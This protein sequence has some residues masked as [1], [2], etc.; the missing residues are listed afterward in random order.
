MSSSP[1][2]DYV[3]TVSS[4]TETKQ[5]LTFDAWNGMGKGVTS[6]I[7]M[8]K[9]RSLA[10]KRQHHH[11]WRYQRESYK[12]QNIVAQ[13]KMGLH[14]RGEYGAPTRQLLQNK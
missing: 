7:L 11:P 10:A 5:H 13:E 3:N 14:S 12:P 8:F 2:E 1:V 6:L 9:T 4:R